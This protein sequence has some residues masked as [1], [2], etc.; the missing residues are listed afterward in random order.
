M[1]NRRRFIT[2]AAGAAVGAAYSRIEPPLRWRGVAMGADV[3]IDLGPAPGA[4]GEAALAAAVDTIRRMEQLFSIYDPHSAL[5][6]LNRDGRISA[7]PEFSRLINL[8]GRAHVLTGGLFDPTVQPLVMARMQGRTPSVAERARVGWNMVE[9][10]EDEI[11]FRKPGMAMTFNGI[12]QGYATDRVAEVLASHGLTGTVVNIG[13][14][15]IGDRLAAIGIGGA[16]GNI[17]SVKNLAGAAVATSVPGSYLFDDQSSHIM[18]PRSMDA[19]PRWASASVVAN[20]ATM[21]DAFSTALVLANGTA[22]AESLVKGAVRT[23]ILENAAGEIS[24][25]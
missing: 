21:A 15:R 17:L 11:R 3:S 9:I 5:S 2:I 25:I 20:T 23:V 7:G 19:L 6:R 24:H 8:A 22:L 14:Y 1:M 4:K 18:H 13:E 12:A 10:G 16:L